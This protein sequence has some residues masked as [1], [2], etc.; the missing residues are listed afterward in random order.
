MI[1][2]SLYLQSNESFSVSVGLNTELPKPYLS[3]DVN[4]SLPFV[5]SKLLSKVIVFTIYISNRD[6]FRI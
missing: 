3:F 4:E 6:N 1:L 5:L 2:L